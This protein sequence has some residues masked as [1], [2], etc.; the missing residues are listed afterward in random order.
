VNR[1]FDATAPG[2][3]SAESRWTAVTVGVSAM[4]VWIAVWLAV[5]ALGP[6]LI[7][8]EP[9]AVHSDSM[10]PGIRT[11]DVVVVAPYDGA[12]LSTG[13]VIAYRTGPDDRLV[14][15]RIAEV[16]DG[17]YRTKGDANQTADSTPV[18][19]DQIEGV[20][21]ILVPMAGWPVHWLATGRWWLAL[22]VA[23]SL[24]L[25]WWTQ[26]PPT[27]GA[28]PGTTTRRAAPRGLRRRQAVGVLVVVAGANLVPATPLADAAFF[29]TTGNV[30]D[31]FAA[32]AWQI[33]A[34]A[35][36]TCRNTGPFDGWCWGEN[37]NGQIGDGTT[38][39]RSVPT[40]VA[41]FLDAAAASPAGGDAHSCVVADDG[42]VLCW[43][44]NS[45]E[46]LGDGTST[47]RYRPVTVLGVGGT[48]VL[49]DIVAVDAGDG[50]A[51]TCAVDDSG[52]MYCW[53]RNNK[54]QLGVGTTTDSATPVQV[55]G[56][57]GSG[58][59]TGITALGLGTEHA[60]AVNGSGAVF[61]WGNGADGRRGDGTT[62]N[63]S[64][65]V[66]VVGVGGSGTLSGIAGVVAGES[67]T[68]ARTTG[69]AVYC[70][71]RNDRGQLGDGTTTSSS[72]PVQVKG[73]GG[74]GT[75]SGVMALAAGKKFVCAVRTDGTV[76]C[77][78]EN[79]EEQLGDGTSTNRS[80]P[81]QVIGVGGAGTLTGAVAAAAGESHVCARRTDGSAVCWGRNDKG[82]LGDGTTSD[83]T[84]P[85]V[86]S[87]LG[88]AT[89]IAA[90]AKFSCAVTG[91]S[92]MYCW[93]DNPSGQLGT[94]TT[95]GSS[96]PDRVIGVAGHPM[97]DVLTV[98][99]GLKHSCMSL[100][101]LSVHCWGRNDRGQVGD[102]TTSD[103]AVPAAVVGTSGAGHLSGVRQ[104]VAGDEH[105]CAL[106]SDTTVVCWGRNDKGQLG[107][108]KATGDTSTPQV[109]KGVG[110]SGT[111][112]G[113]TWLSAGVKHTCAATTSGGV[114][115][116][117][118]NANGQV[119]DNT[120]TDRSVPVQ[121]TGVGG[122]GTLGSI[123]Q[124]GAGANHSCA[125]ST[126][127]AVYC[128]GSNSSGQLGDATTTQ[129]PAPV[130]VTAIGGTGTLGNVR[131]VDG[132]VEHSCAATLADS[133][134]CWGRNDKGQVGDGT[135]TSPR[136]SPRQV[137][138]TSGSGSLA[139]VSAVAAGSEHSCAFR[140]DATA[141]YCWGRNDK[142]Q[143]GNDKATGDSA[144]PVV[145]SGP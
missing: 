77:W 66:Q 52:A 99:A 60:C 108:D 69:G 22:A 56:V 87:G 84:S 33:A 73:V 18:H 76:V 3:G 110:G 31:G 104:V 54:G 47:D 35:K 41:G 78:G 89:H 118:L 11:G 42:T 106:L 127:A 39:D 53:G 97:D 144:V 101:D 135:T 68:C 126:A 115:C 16:G 30:D 9:L 129:R 92:H 62:G 24:L 57:G 80:T 71:G 136:T 6:A 23:A 61:C 120:T 112:S 93:G 133:V 65:P 102:G 119:G 37:A 114:V 140:R 134:V 103:T 48:G 74:S 138:S 109:V 7:G 98:A 113:V 107:N 139:S 75:L 20:A 45:E 111:L 12:D 85:V 63:S 51:F 4:Y 81:V 64:T 128:W 44:E 95:A 94:G 32:F 26:L 91:E 130:Q 36:F 96:H 14:L 124:V 58:T 122:S 121:V 55:V 125:V 40:G 43:G 72:S 29:D 59:L 141:A 137:V 145:T 82:Q 8:W 49:G 2:P 143:L 10:A 117:G 83:S 131:W 116:W 19:P 50:G 27:R 132:G 13:S 79:N 86:V 38:T 15:H 70:W 123:R 25:A 1:R 34:T 67:H 21:R 90:G 142:G 17:A 28:A 88:D 46:Q 105:T 100:M 5:L